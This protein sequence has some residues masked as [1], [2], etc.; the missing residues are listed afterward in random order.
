[1]SFEA[2][3]RKREW[4]PTHGVCALASSRTQ[5]VR[6]SLDGLPWACGGAS[7]NDRTL[8]VRN[9]P[10]IGQVIANF[11]YNWLVKSLVVGDLNQ[12]EAR[13]DNRA[14]SEVPEMPIL[15]GVLAFS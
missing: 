14:S 1:M 9:L 5:Q 8:T 7:A 11:R 2:T 10:A 13:A 12:A 3:S 15:I 6:M 4:R